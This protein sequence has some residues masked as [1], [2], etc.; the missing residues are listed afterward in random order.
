M[1]SVRWSERVCTQ[2]YPTAEN[3]KTKIKP[4]FQFGLLFV[5]AVKFMKQFK[6]KKR[7][8]KEQKAILVQMLMLKITILN[9]CFCNILQHSIQ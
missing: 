8:E 4:S 3:G 2:S 1:R 9:D 5:E 6:I 7:R